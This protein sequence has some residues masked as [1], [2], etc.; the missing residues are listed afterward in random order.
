MNYTE[1]YQELVREFRLGSDLRLSSSGI[2]IQFFDFKSNYISQKQGGVNVDTDTEN[3]QFVYPVFVPAKTRKFDKAILLL[4]VVRNAP[5][6]T[7]VCI[8]AEFRLGDVEF[9]FRPKF[10][11][12]NKR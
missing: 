4:H 12:Q 6:Q 5:F 1:R 11:G 2:D 10:C 3:F 8:G 9:A 7:T